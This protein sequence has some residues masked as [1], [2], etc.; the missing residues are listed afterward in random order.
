LFSKSGHTLRM[1]TT[2]SATSSSSAAVFKPN[3]KCKS[4]RLPPLLGTRTKQ[5]G[6]QG[7]FKYT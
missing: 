1:L 4:V 3:R 2:S 6:Q 7:T 5:R